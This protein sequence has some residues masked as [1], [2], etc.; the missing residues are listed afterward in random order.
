MVNVNI[1]YRW[2]FASTQQVLGSDGGIV[3]ETKTTGQ[4]GKGMVSWRATEGVG[5]CP[6]H[7]LINSALRPVPIAPPNRRLSQV[8]ALIGQAVSGLM[9]SGLTNWPIL[10]SSPCVYQDGYLE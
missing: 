4:V 10:D 3:D 7:Q 2:A 1:E 8:S 5:R 9:E 6:R